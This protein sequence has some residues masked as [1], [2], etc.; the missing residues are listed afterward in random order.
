MTS[1]TSARL[2]RFASAHSFCAANSASRNRA[3]NNGAPPLSSDYRSRTPGA[4]AGQD[5][6]S[7]TSSSR[8][9]KGPWT[10]PEWPRD[11]CSSLYEVLQVPAGANG[12]QIKA[13]YRRLAME[14]HPD[15]A[16]AEKKEE[17]TK[18]FCEVQAAYAVLS[19]PSARAAYDVKQSLIAIK[20]VQAANMRSSN[21]TSTSS[22]ARTAAASP[23]FSKA[24]YNN[25]Q[26]RPMHTKLG[27]NWE[28]DQCWC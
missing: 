26:P 24:A 25:M 20:A 7:T 4:P 17:K 10:V 1:V 9:C 19:D 23:A 3:D 28:T 18:L 13:A 11:R 22:S 15:R 16:A 2:F 12:E 14:L 5:F 8:S 21:Y 27:R 6:R